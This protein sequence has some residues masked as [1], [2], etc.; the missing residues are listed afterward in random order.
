[1]E[2]TRKLPTVALTVHPALKDVPEWSEDDP[3]FESLC[4]S[5]HKRGILQ[6]LIVDS[7]SRIV[8]GR[9]RWRGGK[10]LKL[11]EVPVHV[12]SDDEALAII[13]DTLA[14]RRH[15]T[16]GALAYMLVPIVSDK[17]KSVS[18]IAEETGISQRVIEQAIE[19]L[20]IFTE[21]EDYKE[22]VEAK[23]LSGEVGLGAVIAGWAGRQ[24]T[25]GQ[26]KKQVTQLEL[27]D[28]SLTDFQ[29][30]F[31]SWGK[32]DI[33][34]KNAVYARLQTVV[35]AMPEELLLKLTTRISSEIK[36]RKAMK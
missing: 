19:V 32:F 30:R 23:I 27:W 16:K 14:Q 31:A 29:K 25:K 20:K 5:I 1:M 36:Q 18:A 34:A 35:E 28:R 8:D 10:R 3:Q 4:R 12:V 15:Y 22:E 11:E 21:A 6:P 26:S 17:K 7:K 24:A 9:H 2:H 33:G 13:I